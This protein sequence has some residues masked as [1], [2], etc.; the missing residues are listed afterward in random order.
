LGSSPMLFFIHIFIHS[1]ICSITG[2]WFPGLC[3]LLIYRWWKERRN[4]GKTTLD[5]L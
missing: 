5:T 2:H 4:G 1:T 3:F